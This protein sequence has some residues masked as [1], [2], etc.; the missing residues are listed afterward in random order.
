MSQN[1]EQITIRVPKRLLKLAEAEAKR[2]SPLVQ[3]RSDVLRMALEQ[4]MKRV[5]K[6]T[7]P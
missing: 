2:L 6:I 4:G 1:Q 5:Q 7:V 3:S